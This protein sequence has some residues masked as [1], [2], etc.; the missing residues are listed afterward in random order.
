MD[1]SIRTRGIEYHSSIHLRSVDREYVYHAPELANP[2]RFISLMFLVAGLQS[3][4]F[5]IA[6]RHKR[7]RIIMYTE[8]VSTFLSST[9]AVIYCYYSRD[10]WG[11]IYAT[12]LNRAL[13]TPP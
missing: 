10:Y 9:F 6:I 1:P 4:S 8:L 13:L 12:V 11:L 3:M 5:P 7:S 2:L